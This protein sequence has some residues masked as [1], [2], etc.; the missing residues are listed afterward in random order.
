MSITSKIKWF[1]A[2]F[3]CNPNTV[4]YEP[5]DD[6]FEGIKELD[7]VLEDTNRQRVGH[8]KDCEKHRYDDEGLCYCILEVKHIPMDERHESLQCND[9]IHHCWQEK[10][11]K[12][13]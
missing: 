10:Y 4:E 8:Q 13:D 6:W 12:K 11:W 1:R 5:V 2:L 9:C 3:H 7:E